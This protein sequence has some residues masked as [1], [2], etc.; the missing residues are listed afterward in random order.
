MLW[1]HGFLGC[2]CPLCY[3]LYVLQVLI[4]GKKKKKKEKYMS[5]NSQM[6]TAQNVF[7]VLM[8]EISDFIYRIFI[9]TASLAV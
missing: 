2:L 5:V 6:M 7:L 3:F 4:V 8:C 9:Q 1:L